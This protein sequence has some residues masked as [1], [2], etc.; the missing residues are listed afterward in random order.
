[1]A[2]TVN[3][4]TPAS[5]DDRTE[6]L[7][8]WR[9]I[10][11]QAVIAVGTAFL[12]MTLAVSLFTGAAVAQSDDGGDDISDEQNFCDNEIMVWIRNATG[13]LTVA[14]PSVG[15]LNA[16]WN[17]V[18][19]SGTNKSQKKKESKE[20]IQSALKYGF[21]LGALGIIVGLI[22]TWGPVSVCSF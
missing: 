12:L 7:I 20:N 17:M 9:T 11:Y 8:Q 16:G 4:H 6:S 18:K 13:F 1:M 5:D 22:T 3:S 19:A 21:A 15:V 10:G 2:H 14:G